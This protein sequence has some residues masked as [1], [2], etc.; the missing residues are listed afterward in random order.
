MF[1]Y[2]SV[3]EAVGTSVLDLYVDP[4]EREPLLERLKQQGKIER[5]EVWRKRRD[6]KPIYIVENLVGHFNERGEL[7]EIQGYLFDD[8]RAS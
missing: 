7:Y 1:G 5:L 8:A 4:G 3:E 6:G 2:S